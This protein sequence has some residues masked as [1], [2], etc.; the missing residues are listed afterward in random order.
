[1]AAVAEASCRM[2]PARFGQPSLRFAGRKAASPAQEPSWISQARF[3]VPSFGLTCRRAA[4]SIFM[5]SKVDPPNVAQLCEKARLTLAPEEVRCLILVTNLVTH[6][7]ALP[8]TVSRSRSARSWTDSLDM[9]FSGTCYV[10]FFSFLIVVLSS[11]F[12]QFFLQNNMIGYLI[13]N[14][15]IDIAFSRAK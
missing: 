13:G 8:Q 15:E 9:A 1:M 6:A 4:M 12:R 5:A 14:Q 10:P 11:A 7:L 2:L 3:C